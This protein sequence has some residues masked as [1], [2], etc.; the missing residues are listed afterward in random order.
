MNVEE[1]ID[2][3]SM[4]FLY[5]KE[6]LS[7]EYRMSLV[8]D[9]HDIRERMQKYSLFKSSHVRRGKSLQMCRSIFQNGLV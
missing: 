6:R 7:L 5:P 8:V 4:L 1:S 2:H 3:R 9:R